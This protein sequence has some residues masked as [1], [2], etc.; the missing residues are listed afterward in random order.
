MVRAVRIAMM[1]TCATVPVAAWG[2]QRP[3]GDYG[4]TVVAVGRCA[5]AANSQAGS[6]GEKRV[7][8]AIAAAAISQG[9]NLIGKALGEAGKAKT[10]STTASRNM[11]P[12]AQSFPQCIQVVR[13]RMWSAAPTSG[14]PG[15]AD[16]LEVARPELASN[17]TYPA[18][19][20]DFFFEGEIIGS[21]DNTSLAIRPTASYLRTPIG[22]RTFRSGRGRSIAVF[23]AITSPGTKP[24][25]ESAPAA[26]LI[27]G[28]HE[29]GRLVR[30][31]ER[32]GSSSSPR[33]SA[34]FTLARP[35]AAK[36]L[37]ATALVTETQGESGFLTFVASV[38][39]D[40]KVKTEVTT[41]LQQAFIPAVGAAAAAAED[42]KLATKRSAAET[43]YVAAL[44]KVKD[45]MAAPIATVLQSGTEAKSALRAFVAAD[46]ALP[47]GDPVRMGSLSLVRVETIDLSKPVAIASACKSIH[48]DYLIVP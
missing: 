33:E 26:S 37:T 30:Y 48:D 41:E 19:T 27:L 1:V 39:G 25:L 20:P 21:S 44:S 34:W 45:C 40:E 5:F 43:A 47:V 29:T 7:L 42:A 12:T 14:Q 18:A 6:P 32:T 17:G 38:F 31:P 35:Q 2:E 24:S 15:W 10:W 16:G 36:P 9:V 22:E 8:G 11:E 46:L 28:E 4:A 23:V 3:A 13:G